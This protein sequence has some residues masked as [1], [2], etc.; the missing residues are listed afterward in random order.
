MHVQTIHIRH[1]VTENKYQAQADNL[2]C[3]RRLTDCDFTQNW[4]K[5]ANMQTA[6]LAQV[7]GHLHSKYINHLCMSRQYTLGT[8]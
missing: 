4:P 1:R 8:E 5:C 2:L 6:T 3:G 7:F